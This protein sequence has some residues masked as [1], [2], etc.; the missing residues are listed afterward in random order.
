MEEPYVTAGN[1]ALALEMSW[2][3][4]LK[5]AVENNMMIAED[6]G[7]GFEFIHEDSG[8]DVEVPDPPH[9]SAATMQAVKR[10]HENTGH[11]SM[12]RLARALMV[13]GAPLEAVVAAKNLRCSVCSEQ[14]RMKPPKPASLPVPKD[15]NDQVHIDLFQVMDAGETNHFIVHMTDYTSDISLAGVLQNK[16]TGAVVS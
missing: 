4:K 5:L 12:K 13:S 1:E 6:G 11:R 14:K 16:S 9:V 2:M 8:S 10:L 15:V 3:L 7:Q